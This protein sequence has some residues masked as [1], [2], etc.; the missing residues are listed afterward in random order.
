MYGGGSD[1]TGQTPPPLPPITPL[2]SI[3]HNVTF[4]GQHDIISAS[5]SGQSGSQAEEGCDSLD[6]GSVFLQDG[7]NS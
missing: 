4:K 1:R 2:T 7:A 6:R 5:D 3:T